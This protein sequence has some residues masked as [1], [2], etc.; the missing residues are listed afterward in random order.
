V[1][2]R[3]CAAGCGTSLE[4][5]RA[6][7]K[8]CSE[9]CRLWVYNNPELPARLICRYC[10][11]CI[12]RRRTSFCSGACRR[13]YFKPPRWNRHTC[14]E[15]QGEFWRNVGST[16]ASGRVFCC[17]RCEIANCR[18]RPQTKAGWDVRR[19]RK[20]GAFDERVNP[21]VIAERDGWRCHLCGKVIPKTTKYPNPQSFSLD[22]VVPLVR[23]GRHSYVNV[24]AAHLRCNLS[25]HDRAQ[26][27]QLMMIGTV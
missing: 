14:H 19:A 18:K 12:I 6:H 7:A 17:R 15:C 5:K 10:G 24:R 3:N 16:T 25:K 27:E 4:G 11:D 2:N 26:G 9:A 21:A 8:W 23:G 20:L 22:H 1:S 13:R